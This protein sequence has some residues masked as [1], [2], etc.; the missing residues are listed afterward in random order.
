MLTVLMLALV[1]AFCVNADKPTSPPASNTLTIADV[2]VSGN[3]TILVAALKAADGKLLAAVT[4]SSTAV[5]VFAPTDAAFQAAI[6]SLNTTAA[7][8]LANKPLITK[9]LEFHISPSIVM[10]KEATMHG[11][12]VS[13]LLPG[14]DLLVTKKGLGSK[15]KVFV[16]GYKTKAKVLKADML[17][18]A[19]VV[20]VI[21]KVLIP[22]LS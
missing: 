20:H 9:I 1:S 18:G 10:S 13:T 12:K 14:Q 6:T 5:T 4:N 15:A 16:T 19:S 11:V 8:L 7:A 2:A 3:L 21:D 17:A 22:N